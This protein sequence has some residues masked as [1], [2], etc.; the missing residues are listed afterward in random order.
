MTYRPA[1]DEQLAI[2]ARAGIAESIA[3]FSILRPELDRTG[4]IA[5]TCEWTGCTAEEAEQAIEALI[6]KLQ[7]PVRLGMAAE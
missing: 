7:A 1:T 2:E 3:G 5:A 6:A 4:L